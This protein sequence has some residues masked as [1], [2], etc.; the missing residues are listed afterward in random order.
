M[1][2]IVLGGYGALGRAAATA[3]GAWFPGDVIAAGRSLARAQLLTTATGATVLP[4]QVDLSHPG[5][6]DR[7]LDGAQVLV[8]C[9]EHDNVRV[10]AACLQRGIHYV[11]VSA[12]YPVLAGIERLDGL[13]RR[14]SAAAVLSVGLA[15][16]LT[17]LLASDCARH[18]ESV[19]GVDIAVLLGLGERHGRAAVEWTLDTLHAKPPPARPQ[20]VRFPGEARC[21]TTYPFGFSDQYTLRR[22][23]GVNTV[24]TRLCFDSGSLT[25]SLFLVRRTGALRVLRSPR[26]R[27]A[28]T[29]AIPKLHIGN[30]AFAVVARAHG[31]N[32]TVTGSISGH[33]QSQVSG[34][35]T[36]E[37]ARQLH[38]AAVPPGVHHIE[39]ITDL[40]TMSAALREHRW[41]LTRHR[42]AIQ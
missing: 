5:E 23:L 33:N 35:V 38:T 11:D 3:L 39:H 25:R 36:A 40:D 21:R 7:L 28:L 20:R 14:H 18:L 41:P 30:D 8:A 32:C 31:D 4:A 26:L 22:T 27:R 13:A 16:G 1:T 10:A 24:T 2:I 9:V 17:N 19:S 15:P 12:S 6:L 34:L 42:L 29:A 37:I